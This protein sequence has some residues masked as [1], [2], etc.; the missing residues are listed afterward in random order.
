MR[1][2]SQVVN[3]SL[4]T[5]VKLLTEA[6]DACAAFHDETV[7]SVQAKRVRCDVIWSC[8]QRH[9][10]TP[11]RASDG[12]NDIWTWTALDDDSRL[13]VSYLIGARDAGC[14]YKLVQD[15]AAR[16]AN[17]VQ[18]TLDRNRA[19]LDIAN[20]PISANLDFTKLV[21]LYGEMPH[22]PGR[23]S[24]AQRINAPHQ[25]VKGQSGPAH[26]RNLA[27]SMPM[28]RFTGTTTV[29][30]KKAEAHC[31]VVALY[32][33]WYNFV[34]TLETLRVSPAIA[35]GLS[36]RLWGM[37]DVVALIEAQAEPTLR[38]IAQ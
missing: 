10:P 19:Y 9:V 38:S 17:P 36:T 12:A 32:T 15:V 31:H 20:G 25:C 29:L 33:V 18:L 2:V 13:I 5:I 6:G 21:N 7:R 24:A 1:S 4:K 3:V 14:A 35:A 37:E 34:R 11:E 23:Y 27:I 30:S 26:V 22:L 28:R 8:P 16:L